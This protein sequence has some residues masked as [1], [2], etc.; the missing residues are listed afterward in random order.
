MN[1]IRASLAAALCIAV[2][3]TPVSA[4]VATSGPCG[5][6]SS[7]PAMDQLKGAAAT[8]DMSGVTG[9]G[10]PQ[11]ATTPTALPGATVSTTTVKTPTA[12]TVP[13]VTDQSDH[14][15]SSGGGFFSGL[16]DLTHGLPINQTLA[17]TG[18]GAA[19]G[20]LLLAATPV[21]IIGGLLIGGLIGAVLGS[22]IIGKLMGQGG[23][24]GS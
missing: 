13:S 9:D 1:R 19:I 6:K 14:K 23:S 5:G 20:M 24:G 2:S 4:Q 17:G 21:G 16:K 7:T 3:C 18:F 10:C 22:G 15:D 8:G 12:A 11:T